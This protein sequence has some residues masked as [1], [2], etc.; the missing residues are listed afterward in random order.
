M[1]LPA[2]SEQLINVGEGE[3]KESLRKQGFVCVCVWETEKIETEEN[4]CV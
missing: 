3:M 4:I 1:S 2:S